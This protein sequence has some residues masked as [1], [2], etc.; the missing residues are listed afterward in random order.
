QWPV[1]DNIIL[2]V[3]L[4]R[5]R[6][7]AN[8][9]LDAFLLHQPRNAQQPRRLARL[10]FAG[11]KLKSRTINPHPVHK[12]LSPVAAQLDQHRLP[13]FTDREEQVPLL[14]KPVIDARTVLLEIGRHVAAVKDRDQPAA[15]DTQLS[16]RQSTQSVVSE[17]RH[18]GVI[19]WTLRQKRR[20]PIEE[21]ERQGV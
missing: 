9:E 11:T 14:E 4:P 20:G 17:V 10:Q 2:E 15:H 12:N 13:P 1:A 21:F 3:P 5:L 6:S 8:R 16:Q 19:S 18:D 7:R